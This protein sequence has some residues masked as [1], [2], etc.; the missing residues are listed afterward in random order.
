MKKIFL[1]G[2]VLCITCSIIATSCVKKEMIQEKKI[3][4]NPDTRL[5]FANV[6]WKTEYTLFDLI[7]DEPI[8]PIQKNGETIYQIYY[9]SNEDPNPYYGEF[10][11]DE[12]ERFLFYKFKN[13]ETCEK[14]C[15]SK[16]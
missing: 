2:I 16:K 1:L 9:S 14:F 7:S 4:R 15:N 10:T 13:L 3:V 8:F 12:L 5:D 6:F 11:P